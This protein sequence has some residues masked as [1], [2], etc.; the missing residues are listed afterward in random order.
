M[1]NVT[2]YT[3]FKR[4]ITNAVTGMS[5]GI[6]N[7]LEM[8]KTISNPSSNTVATVTSSMNL[9]GSAASLAKFGKQA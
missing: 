5:G 6:A 8:G 3:S 7:S 2:V 4:D 1:A 9:A